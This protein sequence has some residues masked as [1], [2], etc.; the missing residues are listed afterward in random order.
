MRS[1]ARAWIPPLVALLSGACT[2]TG[3]EGAVRP[4]PTFTRWNPYTAEDLNRDIVVCAEES[5]SSL[6]AELGPEPPA[7]GPEL[8]RA[9]HERTAACMQRRGWKEVRT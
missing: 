6:T 8:R 4:A 3:S 1:A 5:R 2:S 9:L 7:P